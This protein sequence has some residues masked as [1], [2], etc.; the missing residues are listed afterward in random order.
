MKTTNP[1]RPYKL[2]SIEVAPDIK[3]AVYD[4]HNSNNVTTTTTTTLLLIHCTGTHSRTWDFLIDQIPLHIRILTIDLRG[5]GKSTSQ[6]LSTTF[7]NKYPNYKHLWGYN[8]KDILTV[9]YKLNI[10]NNVIGIGHSAGG[11]ALATAAGLD[12]TNIIFKRIVLLDPVIFTN[13]H[14]LKFQNGYGNDPIFSMPSKGTLKRKYQF[15]EKNEMYKRFENKMPYA[16]WNKSILADYIYYG[17]KQVM[18]VRNVND[19]TDNTN[20]NNNVHYELICPPNIESEWYATECLP[21]ANIRTLLSKITVPNI[22]LIRAKERSACDPLLIQCFNH[23][24]V[25][26][27]DIEIDGLTHFVPQQRPDLIINMCNDFFS[28]TSASLS[29]SSSSS[30]TIS[31][32]NGND[33]SS[34]SQHS[35]L[36]LAT[37]FCHA[38]A[39]S[40]QWNRANKGLIPPNLQVVSAT[41]G[42]D[43]IG[44]GKIGGDVGIFKLEVVPTLQNSM[45]A[46]HGGAQA[47]LVDTLT[48]TILSAAQAH[49]QFY[50]D[51]NT[52]GKKRKTIEFRD[53][54][55][56]SLNID[57]LSGGKPGKT[58]YARAC[59]DRAGGSLAF[60]SMTMYNIENDGT[61]T[62]ISKGTHVKVMSKPGKGRSIPIHLFNQRIDEMSVNRRDNND[63]DVQKSAAAAGI[64]K[65][66]EDYNTAK[67]SKL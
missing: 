9:L 28:S 57:Y 21:D 61:E 3:L 31:N 50:D 7:Q 10:I 30:G 22:D 45:K 41:R 24:I 13:E 27:N 55:T 59:V 56:V 20:I 47:T 64:E 17:L 54:G 29:L 65:L 48:T 53:R 63:D 39:S 46:M 11:H 2:H 34:T 66:N 44:T 5:H 38:R 42:K 43:T 1:T 36:Q 62:I 35:F 51:L 52:S 12:P 58:V 37:Y 67:N 4:Y 32:N 49:E 16:V 26:V 23:N 33:H 14:Y 40:S 19:N 25:K 15:L 60:L 18:V 6:F 8:G